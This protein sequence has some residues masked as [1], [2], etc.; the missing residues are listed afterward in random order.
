MTA[1]PARSIGAG[2]AWTFGWIALIVLLGL[3]ISG[4]DASGVGCGTVF[5][6]AA[7]LEDA[8][9][10]ACAA[11]LEARLESTELVAV[12]AALCFVAVLGRLLLNRWTGGRAGGRTM[13]AIPI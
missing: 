8:S 11:A 13:R 9:R 5:S 3:M 1:A 12:I 6:P 10:I 2:A 4:V 7:G